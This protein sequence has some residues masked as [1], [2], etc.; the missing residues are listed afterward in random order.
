MRGT[1]TPQSKPRGARCADGKPAVC[2]DV[3]GGTGD[4]S[5][6]IADSVRRSYLR[7]SPPPHI[8]VCD[9]NEAMLGVGRERATAAGYLGATLI[10][11][12]APPMLIAPAPRCTAAL[13]LADT[14]DVEAPRLSFLQGNAEELPLP[15][16]SVDLY[17]IAFGIRNVTHVDRALRDAYRVLKPGGR[18]MCLEFSRVEVPGIAQLYD[19]V[20]GHAARM[21]HGWGRTK[22][23]RALAPTRAQYSF[24]V[25]PA[26]GSA[27]AG[28]GA[29][30]QYLVESIRK[31]PSQQAFADM[32]AEAGFQHVTYT[33]LTLG[34]CAIHSGF[35]FPAATPAQPPP[36]P[37][38]Q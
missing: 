8:I 33:N 20:R 22:R 12:H 19:A 23:R 29:S 35:K 6:R 2:L 13:A 4:I 15:D 31:F 1:A 24:N 18:F 36:P 17:T 16:A 27:V 26:L 5:F 28:D 32:I 38:L 10:D 30:Y 3:A 21:A 9:I 34:V 11:V 37:P 25:I 14:A 7:S